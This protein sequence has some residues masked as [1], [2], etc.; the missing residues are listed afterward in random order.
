MPSQPHLLLVSTVPVFIQSFLLPYA[1]HFRTLGWTVD[2]MAN[3]ITSNREVRDAFDKVWDVDWSRNP[4]SPANF[5][6]APAVIRQA[7]KSRQYDIVHVHTPVAGLVCRYALRNETKAI[8]IYTAHGFH[9][10]EHGARWK[11][12]LFFRLE[13]LAGKWTDC[14]VL[15]NKEDETAARRRRIVSDDRIVYMPGIGIKRSDYQSE[16]ANG[17]AAAQLRSQLDIPQAC[18]LVLMIAEFIPRKRHIDA[19]Q[20]FSQM[21]RQEAHLLLAGDGDLK[22]EMRQ[23][24]RQH[25]LGS[26][27]HFVGFRRD[28]PTLLSAAAVN[29]LPSEQEGLPKSIMEAMC[30]GVPVIGADI[31]G[32]RDLLGEDAGI[33]VPLGDAKRLAESIDWVL[34]HPA[35]AAEMTKTGAS[36]MERYDCEHIA[37]L[38]QN[39]YAKLMQQKGR[40]KIPDENAPAAASLVEN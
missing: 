7:M 38:H 37:S 22:K 40:N 35:E 39:L 30:M 1:N 28:I 2:G 11:N 14:L 5:L 8:R 17:K 26:R 13:R 4:L 20:A 34:D 33:L 6:R 15:I 25:N 18:P 3:G 12:Q 32:T 16:V 23:L 27:V 21:K 9:F 19:I 31:R 36:R 10:H 29:I 24:V